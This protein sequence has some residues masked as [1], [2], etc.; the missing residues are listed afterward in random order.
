MAGGDAVRI[1]DAEFPMD[2]VKQLTTRAAEKMKV[3]LMTF[4][5]TAANNAIRFLLFYRIP[6]SRNS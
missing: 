1:K 5:D 6:V 4:L 2:S 3:V